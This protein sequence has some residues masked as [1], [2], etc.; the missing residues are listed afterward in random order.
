[1]SSKASNSVMTRARAKY[2]SRLT[3]D[4]YG[5][6][7]G[8]AGLAEVVSYLRTRTHFAPFFEKL[9]T[10]PQLSKI[11]LENA[12][13]TA[14][15]TEAQRLCGFEK[16]VGSSIFRYIAVTRETELIL[17]YIINLSLGTP[18][19][20]ILKTP[21]KYNCGTKIDFSKLFQIKSATELSKYLAKTGYSKL[22]AVLPGKDGGEFDISLIEATLGRIK[23]KM[24]LDEINR[25]FPAETAKILSHGILMRAEL[26][27]INMIYRAKKY[28]GLSESY[29]RTNMMGYRCLLSAKLFDGILAS[30]TSEEALK[31][32]K[33][34]RYAS[35]IDKHGIDDFEIFCEK[36]VIDDDIKQI[37]FSADP[38]VVLSSYLRILEAECDNVTKI[39]EGISYKVPKEEI[40]SNLIIIEKG[41]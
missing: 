40:L 26:A 20:M 10:D 32:L 39:I 37:H 12:L 41:A 11:K 7:A 31:I 24:L 30:K 19:K 23:Y 21:E 29:I 18:E 27:D 38:A 17:D 13:K 36:A 16:S 5:A 22:V 34:S 3:A 6:L 15:I 25:V 35:K 1:M 9:A 8:L 28:Y 2:G 33:G 14:F 4:D